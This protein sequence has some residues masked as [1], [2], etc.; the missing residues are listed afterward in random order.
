MDMTSICV[1]TGRIYSLTTIPFNYG[2]TEY[3]LLVMNNQKIHGNTNTQLWN[4]E[5]TSRDRNR[6]VER[7]QDHLLCHAWCEP[8]S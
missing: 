1:E 3:R 2:R 7:E 5:L 4:A 8:V 6:E